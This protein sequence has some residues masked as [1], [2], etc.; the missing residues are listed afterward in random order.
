MSKKSR[1]ANRRNRPSRNDDINRSSREVLGTLY[2]RRGN[3]TYVAIVT[4]DYNPSQPGE[5]IPAENKA[6]YISST[7]LG[8]R[9]IIHG[10]FLHAIDEAVRPVFRSRRLVS[11]LERGVP[12]DSQAL[13]EQIDPSSGTKIVTLPE[14]EWA[15]AIIHRQEEILRDALLLSGIQVRTLLEDFSGQGNLDVPIYDYDGQPAGSVKLTEIFHTLEH[16]RYCVVSNGFVHDIFSRRGTL[17][18]DRLI[19]SKLKVEE[20]FDAIVEFVSRIRVR[21]FVGVLRGMLVNLSIDSSRHDVIAAIQN[22]SSI[23]QIISE[24]AK[25]HGTPSEF[26]M[27]FANQL[28]V[29]EQRMLDQAGIDNEESVTW[30]K[31][32]GLPRFGIGDRLHERKMRATLMMNGQ[33]ETFEFGWDEF[34]RRLVQAH[35][36]EP[37]VPREV[38]EKRFEHLDGLG[39]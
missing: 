5:T 22:V 9:Q 8:G 32:F 26:A 33:D 38:L 14:A 34:F 20:L 36:D 16:H 17:G 12:A 24:R 25:I 23:A 10:S 19:G 11:E 35:G 1:R 30:T 39:R 13:V 29:D 31:I 6:A 3:L 7:E 37:L 27:F 18:P 15:D 2:Q 28:T 4:V 21:D